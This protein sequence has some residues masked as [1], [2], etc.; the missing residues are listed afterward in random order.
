MYAY[1]KYK[2]KIQNLDFLNECL[3]AR[4]NNNEKTILFKN[5][6]RGYSPNLEIVHGIKDDVEYVHIHDVDTDWSEG[7]NSE[8]IGIVNSALSVGYDENEKKIIKKTGKKS[9]DGKI[10]RKALE[11]T[12][13]EDAL[14]VL[15]N[16][17]NGVRGHTIITTPEK[18]VII[19][20]TS[21]HEAE[22]KEGSDDNIVRTNHGFFHINAG[23]TTGKNYLSSKIRKET[24]E[25]VIDEISDYKDLA[26]KMRQQK[27]K[28]PQLNP[29]RMKGKL[30][31]TSQLLMNLTD[32]EFN[33]YL[34]DDNINTFNGIK[35]DKEL[36]EPK[37]TINI[38]NV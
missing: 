22:T 10:I 17:H 31:T 24:G 11:Q 20:S 2:S 23:Y 15:L 8:G 32:L 33:I 29:T 21:K 3:I 25:A 6:D 1:S 19:E 36:K 14:E 34:I 9:H 18:Y 13:I 38:H 27:N 26:E 5:R 16:L 4:F 37:I 35:K 30:K 28:D 7:M 12:N